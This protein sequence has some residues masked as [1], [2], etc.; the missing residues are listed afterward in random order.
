MADEMSNKKPREKSKKVAKASGYFLVVGG[1][2]TMG[3]WTFC[4]LVKPT[5]N[6]MKV[7]P[8]H[9]IKS[10]F[11][12]A[13]EKAESWPILKKL[14]IQKRGPLVFSICETLVLKSI[15][16]PVALPMKVWLAYKL[17]N[18]SYKN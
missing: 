11:K 6:I 12:K 13:R 4:Y 1:L 15:L 2:Y 7:L 5:T 17:A 3:L 16:A 14:P 9:S 10:S 8:F 18:L